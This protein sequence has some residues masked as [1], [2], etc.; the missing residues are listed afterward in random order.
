MYLFGSFLIRF[1]LSTLLQTKAVYF[2]SFFRVKEF[3]KDFSPKTFLSTESNGGA[4]DE[5]RKRE[6]ERK[7]N[8]QSFSPPLM[9][10]GESK[11]KSKTKAKRTK[12]TA[13]AHEKAF[14]FTHCW[15]EG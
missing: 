9:W 13:K 12:G 8:K 11:S 14:F 6:R 3:K 2:D 7:Q 4:D 10:C 15:P 5:R 1:V